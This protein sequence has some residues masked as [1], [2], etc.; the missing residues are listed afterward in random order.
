MASADAWVIEA[1]AESSHY[2]RALFGF[3][4]DD[5]LA[6]PPD[7]AA[8]RLADPRELHR[9]AYAPLAPPGRPEYA[10]N[11]RGAGFPSLANAYV[12]S[13]YND[14]EGTAILVPPQDVERLMGDYAA[15]LMGVLRLRPGSAREALRLYGRLSIAFGAIH[16][17]VDGN[18]HIQ[19]LTLTFLLRN[20]GFCM[21]PAWSIHPCPYGEPTHRALAAGDI[22]AL[23]AQWAP[24]V[25]E[26]A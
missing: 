25:V 6:L 1:S 14:R 13:A 23:V 16:P 8:R 2:L 12:A 4:L 24:F 10:G 11:F 7:R 3:I 21:A 17:F 19:R 20:A 9:A 22:D 18:G 5:L 15:A 26:R